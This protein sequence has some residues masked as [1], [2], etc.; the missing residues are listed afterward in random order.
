M[1]YFNSNLVATL[2]S[3]R[4]RSA[5]T[6]KEPVGVRSAHGPQDDMTRRAYPASGSGLL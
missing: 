1:L 5:W 3:Y 2:N 4:Y 6:V